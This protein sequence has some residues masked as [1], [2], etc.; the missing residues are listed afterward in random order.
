MCVCKT[1]D[2][3]KSRCNKRTIKTSEIY[4]AQVQYANKLDSSGRQLVDK[5]QP[6]LCMRAFLQGKRTLSV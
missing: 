2:L 6:G 3:N 4:G 5:C 1:I